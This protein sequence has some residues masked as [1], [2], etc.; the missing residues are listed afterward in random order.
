MIQGTSVAAAGDSNLRATEGHAGLHGSQGLEGFEGGTGEDGSIDVTKTGDHRAIAGK[1]HG[2][3]DVPGL[4]KATSFDHCQF[5]RGLN[6][7]RFMRTH[8]HESSLGRGGVS[9]R[10]IRVPARVIRA[11]PA[12]RRA[13]RQARVYRSG[14]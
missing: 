2:R 1:N 4:N 7:E 12:S 13:S 5:H 11:R 3:A 10:V 6:V 14:E 9:S 8:G